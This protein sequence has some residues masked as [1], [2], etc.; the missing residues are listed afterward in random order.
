[1]AG[2]LRK[3][4]RATISP[5]SNFS[6]SHGGEGANS[7]QKELEYHIGSQIPQIA[8][9]ID[10]GGLTRTPT[11]TYTGF[12]QNGSDQGGH[13]TFTFGAANGREHSEVGNS[14]SALSLLSKGTAKLMIGWW[15]SQGYDR[16][17]AS[18]RWIVECVTHDLGLH[19]SCARKRH[20]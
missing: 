12:H 11:C 19:A 8:R 4:Q 16:N 15:H 5:I 3:L 18:P 1:M 13:A 6:V 2:A 7:L 20:D 9:S 14:A 10:D 17:L